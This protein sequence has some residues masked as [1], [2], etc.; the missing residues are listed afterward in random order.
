LTQKFKATFLSYS[1]S[2]AWN[3]LSVSNRFQVQETF[4]I[5]VAEIF[6]VR[7]YNNSLSMNGTR[8]FRELILRTR[9]GKRTLL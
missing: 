8:R 9:D 1:T 2:K 6:M 7:Y 3:A 5:I 4:G